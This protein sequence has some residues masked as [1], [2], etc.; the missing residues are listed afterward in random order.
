MPSLS[1]RAFIVY[2][3]AD[4]V[5]EAEASGCEGKPISALFGGPHV[6]HP[7]LSRYRI[8]LGDEIF[9]VG[10]SKGTLS[11]FLRATIERVLP[12]EEFWRDLSARGLSRP[13]G[14]SWLIPT[15][16]DEGAILR[17]C[18]PLALDRRLAPVELA[19][20]RLAGP[21]GERALRLK[22]GRLSNGGQVQGHYYRISIETAAMFR[23]ITG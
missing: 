8:G 13:R 16:T 3:S 2:W 14:L 6:S 15:C 19:Q 12:L 5:R 22:D 17:D 9:P 21:K 18:T 20:V 4:R 23:K 10:F 11:V 7:R 1:P